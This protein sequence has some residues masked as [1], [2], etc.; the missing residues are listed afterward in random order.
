MLVL[1]ARDPLERHVVERL[2]QAGRGAGEL[3]QR[4]VLDLPGALHLLDD[5]LGVHAH[6]DLSRA[7][8]AR[9]LEPGDQPAVLGDVVRLD[10]DRLVALGQHLAA[11]RV[12]DDGAVA[13]RSG[14]AARAAVGLD[15]DLLELIAG[16]AG[17][18]PDSA[19]RTRIA[20]QLSQRT[21]ASVGAP[22]AP[23]RARCRTA[24][25]GSPRSGV[26]AAARRR[27]RRARGPAR[28]APAGRPACARRA[29]RAAGARSRRPRRRS[30]R[31]RRRRASSRARRCSPATRSCALGRLGQLAVGLLGAFHHLEQLVLE[32]GLAAGQR[33]DLVLQALEL[34]RRADRRPAAAPRRGSCGRARCRRRSPAAAARRRC[35]R[36]WS[37]RRRRR[38]AAAPPT[39]SRS[40]SA[41]SSGR[42]RRRCASWASAVSA[43]CR[44]SRRSWVAVSAFT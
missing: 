19:V 6:G 37:G 25:C 5:E 21:T 3:A 27:C 17:H 14:I 20:R 26:G 22:C 1:L 24:R 8:V 7:E 11:G 34:A 10:A 40:A 4:R 29:R 41:A 33:G 31:R 44:S 13:G 39:V 2:A 28:R 30:R 23:R 42:V 36:P 12:E 16:S 38:R 32:G 9:G 15:D 35:P 18:R 43:A